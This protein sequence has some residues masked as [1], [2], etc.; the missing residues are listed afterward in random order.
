M[1]WP[2]K[3]SRG[4]SDAE[5]VTRPPPSLHA[6]GGAAQRGRDPVVATSVV[7]LFP[8]F[9]WE[10]GACDT[11]SDLMEVPRGPRRDEGSHSDTF[12]S[13]DQ[14]KVRGGVDGALSGAGQTV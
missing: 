13:C 14:R 5:E 2:F 3:G 11:E 6:G 4:L 9:S 1:R 10:I 12:V 8:F 7:F